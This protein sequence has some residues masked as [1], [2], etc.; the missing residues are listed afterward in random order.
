MHAPEPIRLRSLMTSRR[1][2]WSLALLLGFVTFV[3]VV[4]LL[5]LSGWFISAAALAG[6]VS[7]GVGFDY[8]RPAAM[9]RLCAIGRTAGRYAERLSSHYAAL[10]LLKDLRVSRFQLMA[11]SKTAKHHSADDLQRLVSDI[12]LLDLFPLKVVAPWL[13]AIL[14]SALLLLFWAL[15]ANSLLLAAIPL[16]IAAL[17]VPL[18]G[19]ST[20]VKLSRQQADTAAQ[21]RQALLEPLSLLANLVLWQRWQQQLQRFNQ[22][23]RQLLTLQQRQQQLINR[24]VL[25]QHCLLGLSALLLLWQGGAALAQGQLKVPLLLAALLVLWALYEILTPLCHSVV[26]LGLSLAA[27]DR[28]NQ[29]AGP[30]AAQTSGPVPTGP[31]K[32]AASQLTA[33]QPNAIVGPHKISFTLS[34]GQLLFI[35]GVSGAG[36]STLLQALAGELPYRGELSLNGWPLSHWQLNHSIGYLPQQPDLFDLTL[37]QNLRLGAPDASDSELWQVLDDVALKT[38]AQ[39]QPQQLDTLLGEYGAAVSGGQ[40][41]RIALARLLLTKRP[42]LLLDEPFAGLDN[43]TAQQVAKV[44]QQ[45]QQSGLLIIV[46]HQQL[47][48]NHSTTLTLSEQ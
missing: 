29:L 11:Q 28:L 21:R 12:D 20:A 25:L 36:K 23:D 47:Q 32:L 35:N 14:L 5:A 24:T 27:R 15:L 34:S 38:W 46:S 18:L 19:L 7:L 48:L 44:L 42:I 26:A 31:F 39:Q 8:F 6:L 41:R 37:A 16:L 1:G 45:R 43:L 2:A 17:I 3:A 4:T 13:S 9:I 40:G 30:T 33:R 10:G 22:A